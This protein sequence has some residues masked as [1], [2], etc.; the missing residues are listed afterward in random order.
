MVTQMAVAYPDEILRPVAERMAGDS[1]SVLPVVDRRDPTRLD[2]LITQFD[3]LR[4]RQK[5]LVEERHAE[6][7]LTPRRVGA[8]PPDAG[9]PG[10]SAREPAGAVAPR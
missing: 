6:R 4:A 8:G 5:L 7:L 3:L 2:G 10:G 1:I 9:A